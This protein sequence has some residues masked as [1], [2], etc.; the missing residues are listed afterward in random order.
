[1]DV[2]VGLAIILAALAAVV[3]GAL[4]GANVR[5]R[6]KGRQ[7]PAPGDSRRVSAEQARYYYKV[8]QDAVR[9]LDRLAEDDMTRVVIPEDTLARI[10]AI[11]ARFY[12]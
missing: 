11:S 2:L 3:T 7:A 12:K 6:S 1:M 5:T 9:V 4:V 10:D 8:A